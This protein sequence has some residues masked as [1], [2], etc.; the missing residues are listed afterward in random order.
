MLIRLQTILQRTLVRYFPEYRVFIK[1]DKNFRYF[2]LKSRVQVIFALIFAATIGWAGIATAILLINSFGIPSSS[3]KMQTDYALYQKHLKILAEELDVKTHETIQSHNRFDMALNQIAEIQ[4]QLIFK[5]KQRQE[6]ETNLKAIQSSLRETTIER[7]KARELIA[8]LVNENPNGLE[9]F[10]HNAIED[11]VSDFMVEALAETAAERDHVKTTAQKRTTELEAEIEFIEN[12]N[13]EI[14]RKLEEAIEVSILPLHKMFN[15]AGLPTDEIIESVRRGYS[16]QGGPDLTS[17]VSE[18][19]EQSAID[20]VRANHLLERLDLINLYM[21]TANKTPFSFPIDG[22]YRFTSGFGYRPDPISKVRKMHNGVD[23]AA[24]HGTDIVATADGYVKFSGWRTGYGKLV[25]LSH[26]FGFE[27]WYAHN[28]KN[29]V[30]KGQK[31]SR[32]D[33]IADMG[34]TG[35]STGVHLHYEIRQS[36]KPINPMIY[37]KAGNDVF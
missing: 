28:S 12:R 15:N 26:S 3:H 2:R 16:G 22:V 1:S 17:S 35:R 20:V 33:H 7:N 29:F 10:D 23:F 5:E 36:G 21:I 13:N 19:N 14:F 24:A 18:K 37:L 34:N 27:T 4:S 11:V 30:K 32:G 25:I 31:V 8:T 6:L 9:I